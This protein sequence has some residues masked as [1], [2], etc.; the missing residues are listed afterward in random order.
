MSDI[1]AKFHQKLREAGLE[2]PPTP[3]VA[4]GQPGVPEGP[5]GAPAPPPGPAPEETNPPAAGEAA[6]PLVQPQGQRFPSNPHRFRFTE[7]EAVCFFNE[8]GQKVEGQISGPPIGDQY[9]VA[10]EGR[11]STVLK[12]EIFYSA[13]GYPTEPGTPASP[14]PTG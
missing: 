2:P 10:H 5:E 1:L 8:R 13:T 11:V 6:D 9:N 3:T 14:V 7:G 4:G 12:S